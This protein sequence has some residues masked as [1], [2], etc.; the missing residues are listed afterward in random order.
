MVVVGLAFSIAGVFALAFC[1]LGRSQLQVSRAGLQAKTF[2]SGWKIND[3][4]LDADAIEE[5]TVGKNNRGKLELRA[6]GDHGALTFASRCLLKNCT[7]C[8]AVSL[9]QCRAAIANAER[10]TIGVNRAR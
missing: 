6:S 2:F 5:I 1:V 10:D 7:S 4:R 3:S 9:L 8:E